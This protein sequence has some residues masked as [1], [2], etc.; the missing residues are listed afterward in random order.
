MKTLIEDARLIITAKPGTSLT[1]AALRCIRER[2]SFDARVEVKEEVVGSRAVC[3][4]CAAPWTNQESFSFNGGCCARDREGAPMDWLRDRLVSKMGRYGSGVT[5]SVG[6]D[7]LK[8]D[9]SAVLR[10][11]GKFDGR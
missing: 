11:L 4:H 5:C 9:R 3:A 8:L 7:G 2:L 10:I 1:P 6:W